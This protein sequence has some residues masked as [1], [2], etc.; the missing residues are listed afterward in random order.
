MAEQTYFVYPTPMGR[1]TLVSDGDYL[2]RAAFGVVDY[3]CKKQA[4]RTTNEAANQVQAY[5]AGK[6]TSFDIALRPVGTDFQREVWDAI[7]RIPYGTTQ[8]YAQIAEAVGNAQ[9]FRAVGMAANKNPLPIFI[10]CHRVVASS[11]KLGG[12]AYSTKIKEFLINL[13]KGTEVHLV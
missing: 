10:P 2:I 9:A 4:S 1:I 8:T 11:G 5:L 3:P 12:Y 7:A 13:E 6:R